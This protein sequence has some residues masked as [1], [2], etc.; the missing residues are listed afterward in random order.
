MFWKTSWIRAVW[1]PL[2]A[3]FLLLVIWQVATHLF[4]LP[5]WVLPSPADIVREGIASLD[6]I[7]GHAV[8]T[9]RLTLLGFA[10]GTAVGLIVSFMLHA[11][12]PLKAALYPLIILSQNIPMI[13]LAPL[14]MIWFGFGLFPKIV[15]ITLVCFFPI[16]VATLNGLL[17][18]DAA[19]LNY[20]KMVGA[21][22][23]QIFF[24]LELPYALPSLFAGLKISAAYSV[25]GAIIGEW[26]GTEKGLGMYMLLQKSAFR[27]D[28]V[29]VSIVLIV[30][31]SLVIF[32]IIAWLE[33]RLI[34]WKPKK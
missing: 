19:M 17:Q 32:G 3:V 26:L 25:M 27:T 2:A 7:R 1:P 6:T 9:L 34:R 30:A 21:T 20:M 5:K 10:I 4:E 15:V 16:V 12:K 11:F 22:K 18:T 13:A 31:L 29:F 28:R 14:L 23:R 24:K 8:S 33:K